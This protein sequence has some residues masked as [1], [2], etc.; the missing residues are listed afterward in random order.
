MLRPGPDRGWRQKVRDPVG[1]R[2]DWFRAPCLSLGDVG[3]LQAPP[4]LCHLVVH[5]LAFFEG[6]EPFASY[7]AEMHEY[8]LAAVIRRDEAVAFILA[9]PLHR[10]LRHTLPP[11]R[12]FPGGQFT[13]ATRTSKREKVGAPTES[14]RTLASQSPC[15]KA[16]PR[17]GVGHS[18]ESR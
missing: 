15:Q 17:T 2:S 18:E 14:V 7:A 1:P 10:S 3:R 5:R 13:L 9:E 11:S 4:A 6:L 16:H 12:Y 8:V